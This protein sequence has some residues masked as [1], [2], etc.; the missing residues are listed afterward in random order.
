MKRA[1]MDGPRG[2]TTAGLLRAPSHPWHTELGLVGK[3]NPSGTKPPIQIPD[4]D[5]KR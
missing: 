1:P 2:D 3:R 4:A 5:R